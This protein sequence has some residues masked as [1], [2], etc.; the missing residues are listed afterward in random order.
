ML[1]PLEIVTIIV[2]VKLLK[3]LSKSLANQPIIQFHDKITTITPTDIEAYLTTSPKIIWKLSYKG[4]F[5]TTSYINVSKYKVYVAPIH[6]GK[7]TY[8]I[9]SIGDKKSLLGQGGLTHSRHE[10]DVELITENKNN[11]YDLSTLYKVT[12]LKNKPYAKLVTYDTLQ[13]ILDQNPY[14]CKYAFAN[15]LNT[16]FMVKVL[17]W[18]REKL[19][20]NL[21]PLF[22]YIKLVHFIK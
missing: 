18:H 1:L 9:N 22:S 20:A 6:I 10:S 11:S 7:Y 16:D 19:I 8:Q 3:Q 15:Y 17:S 21:D 13:Y 14:H 4:K 2:P 5:Y 12:K